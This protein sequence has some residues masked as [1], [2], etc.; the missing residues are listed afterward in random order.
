MLCNSSLLEYCLTT[1]PRIKSTLFNIY[2][3]KISDVLKHGSI[4]KCMC[5]L[6]S[7]GMQTKNT[8]ASFK[9]PFNSLGDGSALRNLHLP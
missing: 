1:V 3:W 5:A 9:E 4:N 7:Y 8:F 6:F 2:R